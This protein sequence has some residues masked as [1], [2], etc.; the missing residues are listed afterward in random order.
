MASELV[1]SGGKWVLQTAAAGGVQWIDIEDLNT[2]WTS[3]D[4]DSLLTSY[5]YNGG[6]KEHSFTLVT[7]PNIGSAYNDYSTSTTLGTFKAPRWSKT[8][9][10]ENGTAL[11]SDDEFMMLFRLESFNPGAVASW[12]TAVVYSRDTTTTNRGTGGW[13]GVAI[14]TSNFLTPTVSAI[15]AGSNVNVTSLANGDKVTGSAQMCGAGRN[16]NVGSYAT[17]MASGNASSTARTGQFTFSASTPLYLEVMC[18][19]QGNVLETTGGTLTMQL[20]YAIV[21]TA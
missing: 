3:S 15:F 6:T 12:S 8:L 13:T 18:P 17:I 20:K 2:G 10:D 9:V 4:P 19:T 5:S 11:T 1:L 14:G 16:K 21:R 7:L